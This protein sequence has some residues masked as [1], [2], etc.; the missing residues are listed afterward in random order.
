M[1]YFFHDVIFIEPGSLGVGG[2]GQVKLAAAATAVS[3]PQEAME[4]NIAVIMGRAG[5][6]CMVICYLPPLPSSPK[7]SASC[8]ES[9][10]P[11]AQQ[12]LHF[13]TNTFTSKLK[14]LFEDLSCFF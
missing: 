10:Q 5:C 1:A 14:G 7:L 13:S 8:N 3:Q 12:T 11:S 9:K 4:V 6:F 2:R